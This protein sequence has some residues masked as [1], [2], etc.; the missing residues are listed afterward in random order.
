MSNGVKVVYGII[1]FLV[2]VNAASALFYATTGAYSWALVC[3][4]I[5]GVLTWSLFSEDREE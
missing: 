3:A 2:L 1:L 5:G 4:L